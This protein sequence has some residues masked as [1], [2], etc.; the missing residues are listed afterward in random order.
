MP[1][2]LTVIV[3]A[4]LVLLDSVSLPA[5]TWM[6]PVKLMAPL[7]FTKLEPDLRRLPP[8]VCSSEMAPTMLYVVVPALS[9]LPVRVSADA[10]LAVPS[11]ML[12]LMV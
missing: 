5:L 4:A 6:P 10:L 12:L 11:W 1:P 7:M 2:L 9:P 3:E 8:P